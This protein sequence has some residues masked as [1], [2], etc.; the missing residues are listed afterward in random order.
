MRGRTVPS[1]P[2]ESPRRPPLGVLALLTTVCVLVF[3]PMAVF[4]YRQAWD[5]WN[6]VRIDGV[7]A[8]IR[9]VRVERPARRAAGPWRVVWE[10]ERDGGGPDRVAVFARGSYTS[11]AKAREASL[12]DLGRSVTAWQVPGDD[13]PGSLDAPDLE[14][15]LFAAVWTTGM[16]AF[17]W[18]GVAAFVQLGRRRWRG[19][20]ST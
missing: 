5:A 4:S 9:L 13:G 3:T 14:R 7:I 8:D 15:G 2:S 10:V 18:L 20:R 17:G 6:A 12:H 16:A 11:E 19:V 1:P